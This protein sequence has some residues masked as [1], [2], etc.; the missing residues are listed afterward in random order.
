MVYVCRK[1]HFNAAHRLY[2]PAWT[3]EKNCEVFGVCANEH[4]H[5]HNFELVVTVKGTPHPETGFVMDMKHLSK[6]IKEDIIEKL[7]H[8]NLNMEVDFLEGKMP[9][10]EVVVM[11]IWRILA[12]RIADVS[13]NRAILHKIQLHETI[14]NSVEYYGE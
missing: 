14:N 13:M 2:N 10:C 7:D 11:E 3:K 9:S 4:F 5:G 8:K 12:P 6:I 1:E